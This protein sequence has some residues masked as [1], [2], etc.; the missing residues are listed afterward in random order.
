MKARSQIGQYAIIAVV[1][2]L[3]F[4]T[5]APFVSAVILGLLVALVARPL[6]QRMRRLVGGRKALSALLTTTLLTMFFVLPLVLVGV[7]VVNQA[8]ELA[9]QL[10]MESIRP[11]YE[12]VI[13]RLPVSPKLLDNSLQSAVSAVGGV[14]TTI[15]KNLASSIPGFALNLILFIVSIYYGLADGRRLATFLHDAMPFEVRETAALESTVETI[16]RGVVLGSLLAGLVQGLIIGL[17]FAFLGIPGAVL[18]GTLT[19]VFSFVPAFGSGPTGLGGAIYLWSQGNGTGALIMLAALGL[20]SVSDNV[21][22]PMV[23][24]GET[25]LHPLLGLISALGGLAVF[26]FAGLFLGPLFAALTI[27]LLKLTRN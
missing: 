1:L 27:V 11:L 25:E 12:Q 16:C 8:I 21:V 14:A 13:S 3:F 10:K 4:L 26:G 9:P 15:L 17:A 20:A 24:S 23:L 19:A 2:G 18:F 6:D 7:E 5:V 22:K